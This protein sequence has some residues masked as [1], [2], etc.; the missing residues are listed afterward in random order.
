[1]NDG[2][3]V[4]VLGATGLVG[5]AMI[6]I[7][8]EREFPV[9]ELFP[10]ASERSA[11][12]KIKFRDREHAVLDVDSF[13]FSRARIGLFSAGASVSAKYAPRAA[14]AGCVVIDNTS[15]FRQDTA[16]PLVVPEVNQE[17]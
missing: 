5:E 3:S 6:T 13:D 2:Y 7:L 15:C 9:S 14:E 11:G 4:A 12:S 8:E 17:A 10:L 16:I 1:M